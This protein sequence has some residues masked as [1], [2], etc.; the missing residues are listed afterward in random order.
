MRPKTETDFEEILEPFAEWE[1]LERDDKRVLLAAFCP[2]IRVER[3]VVKSLMLNCVAEGANEVN[4]SRAAAAVT[5]S[6]L[7]WLPVNS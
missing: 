1:F 7:I 5:T 6:Y 3:Y 2:E 4:Q